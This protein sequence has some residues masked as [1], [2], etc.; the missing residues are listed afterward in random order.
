[1]NLFEQQQHEFTHRHIGPNEQET[2]EML[3]TIG[4]SSLDEL[5]DKTVPGS[6]RANFPLQTSGP[7]SEFQYLK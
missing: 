7:V 5:I 6:I 1:M 3:K 2:A 4:I